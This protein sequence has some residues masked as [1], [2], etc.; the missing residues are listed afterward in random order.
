MSRDARFEGEVTLP[1]TIDDR[2]RNKTAS[3]APRPLSFLARA[4]TVLC[5]LYGIGV[6]VVWVRLSHCPRPTG[7]WPFSCTAPAGSSRPPL[8]LLIPLALARPRLY[9]LLVPVCLVLLGPVM[10]GCLPWRTW[11]PGE[12]GGLR[13][14]AM[15]LNMQGDAC[16]S[17]ELGRLIAAEKPDLIVFVESSPKTQ[18]EALWRGRWYIKRF[19][20]V[21]LASRYPIV[22]MEPLEQEEVRYGAAVRF[23]LDVLGRRVLVFGLHLTTPRGGL[24]AAM[25]LSR[26]TPDAIRESVDLQR[27]ESSRVGR[28]LAARSDRPRL[29]LGDFNMPV[30]SSIYRSNYGSFGNSYSEAGL[31]FGPTKFTRWFGARIDHILHDAHWQ[32]DRAWVG[33]DLG[34][35][36][37]PVFAELRWLDG[38]APAGADRSSPESATSLPQDTPDR[39]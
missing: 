27:M 22:S 1:S 24:E 13:L 21:T 12:S 11:L 9:L 31:G 16:D 29:V 7:W 10:G 4:A 2:D 38:P 37:R 8:A 5:A 34:S 15:S 26:D 28:W 6:L 35:D 33:P 39:P 18:T 30:E 20:G 17:F 23:E 32:A 14:K 25:H 3:P 36:H 19:S